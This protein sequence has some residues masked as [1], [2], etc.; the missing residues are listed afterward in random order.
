MFIRGVGGP[1]PVKP[2]KNTNISKI[3]KGVE[4]NVSKKDEVS[5]SDSA[6]QILEKKKMEETALNII[7]N[8]PDIRPE[9]VE[10]GKRFI[11]SGKYK[12]EESINYVAGK[13]GEEIIAKMIVEKEDN[14]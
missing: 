13:I 9:A 10:R 4:N 7:K 6:K 11:E 8:V 14:S 3:E 12:S 5:I 1:E 2:S